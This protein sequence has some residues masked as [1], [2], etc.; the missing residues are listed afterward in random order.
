MARQAATY[1]AQA[2]PDNGAVLTYTT[3][4]CIA[5]FEIRASPDSHCLVM[6]VDNDGGP[7]KLIM[8]IFVHS[9]MTV[10]VKAPLG[11]YDFCYA[12]GDTWYG[13][14]HLFGPET[15][16][17]KADEVFDFRRTEYPIPGGTRYE[18]TGHT[19]TLYKV[20]NGNLS[21]SPISA[22]YLKGIMETGRGPVE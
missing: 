14:E 17:S 2:L 8:T 4:E 18:V 19:V 5:P 7:K 16:G 10:N 21:T 15:R 3:R 12:S 6:L 9:G 13:Y 11:N 22:D 20:I 1:P